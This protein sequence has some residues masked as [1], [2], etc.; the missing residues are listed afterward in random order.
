MD[1]HNKIDLESYTNRNISLLKMQHLEKLSSNKKKVTTKK[2]VK[3]THSLIKNSSQI[4]L[5]NI[6]FHEVEPP[7]IFKYWLHFM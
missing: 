4:M 6:E 1:G 2:I 5:Q 3:S 7:N